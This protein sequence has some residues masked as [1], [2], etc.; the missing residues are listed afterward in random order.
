M[1]VRGGEDWNSG[2]PN[3]YY[4]G[5]AMSNGVQSGV[6]VLQPNSGLG[7]IGPKRLHI[8]QY[9][10]QGQ[11]SARVVSANGLAISEV[12]WSVSS[13]DFLSASGNLSKKISPCLGLSGAV[14]SG[15][16]QECEVFA[17][18]SRVL[19]NTELDVFLSSAKALGAKRGRAWS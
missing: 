5:R 7:V 4:A 10:G 17:R 2:T 9:D 19:S 8:L 3:P 6:N 1:Y 16:A 18:Y 14:F 13:N 15:G 12:N 11:A